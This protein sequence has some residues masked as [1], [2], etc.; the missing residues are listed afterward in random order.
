MLAGLLLTVLA[1][2]GPYVAEMGPPLVAP[3]LLAGPAS[4]PAGGA[5]IAGDGAAL[6]V[7]IYRPEG[8]PR[9]VI[10]AIHGL[11]DASR[12]FMEPDT[13]PLLTAGGQL[14]YAYDQRGFGRAPDR[15]LWPGTD[16][17]VADARAMVAALRARYPELPLTVLGESMGGAV[18]LLAA[19]QE[20]VPPIDRLVLSA[21]AL[22]S[23]REIGPVASGVL[24][25][26]AYGLPALS[27]PASGGNIRAS[28]NEAALRR[29]STDPLTLKQTRADVGYGLFDLMDR[30]VA[31][32]PR[33]CRM[34]AILLHGEHD[35]LV[36]GG[37]L[38][39]AL[40]AGGETPEGTQG[41]LRLAVYPDGWH[42][43]L[44]DRN[45]EVV[46]RDVLSFLQDPQAPLP[47]GAETRAA[48]WLHE[49]DAP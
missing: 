40:D 36:P 20:P 12:D 27:F 33:C 7:R 30:A 19:T 6:P 17:L 31:A 44:R 49:E 16:A 32:L 2:C 5:L 42:L 4:D 13:A 22:W 21:P 11:N 3:A 45:R 14:V 10:L 8:P 9:G 38:R 39:R 1:G 43:L 48:A 15:G 24:G 28:D 26:L 23:R 35:R 29:F 41:T 18:A 46:A 47:S 34:P 37:V 25:A